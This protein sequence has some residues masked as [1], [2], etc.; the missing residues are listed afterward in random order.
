MRTAIRNFFKP[1]VHFVA[2][3]YARLVSFVRFRSIE[4]LKWQNPRKTTFYKD[5]VFGTKVTNKV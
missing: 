1:N 4:Y 3:N 2:L 5:L